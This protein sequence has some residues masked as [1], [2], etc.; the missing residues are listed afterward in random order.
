MVRDKDAVGAALLDFYNNSYTT[1]IIVKSSISEADVIPIPY[2]FRSEKEL[3][4]LE[5]MALELCK[6]RVLDVGAGSGCHSIILKG[7]GVE[8]LAIDTSEGAVEVMQKRG[9]NS[10][11]INFYNVN[12]KYDTLLFLMN[13]V[14]IAGT[15]NE[16][17]KFLKKAKSLLNSGGQILL[18]SSDIQYMFEEED[19]SLWADLNGDYYGEVNY[20]MQYKNY[21][22]DKFDWLFVDFDKLK[23]VAKSLDLKIELVFE[24]NNNQYL[25]RLFF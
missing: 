6:G 10:Q 20:Q 4:T 12:E 21:T 7:K 11:C 24:D 16:L 18:D 13:G 14:G 3:P 15:L 8:V 9:L 23:R 5:K 1:D 25:A 17:P 22:T 2:L 19:G